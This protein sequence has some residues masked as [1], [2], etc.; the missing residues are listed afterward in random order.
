MTLV[1]IEAHVVVGLLPG[2]VTPNGVDGPDPS[3]QCKRP[4]RSCAAICA[5]QVRASRWTFAE[6]Q[7][8]ALELHQIELFPARRDGHDPEAPC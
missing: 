8:L 3:N 7:P 4:E 1:G 6:Q 2:S 5:A